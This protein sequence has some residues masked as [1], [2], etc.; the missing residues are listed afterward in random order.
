MTRLISVISI[1][2]LTIIGCESKNNGPDRIPDGVYIGTFQR[3]Q[4]FGGGEVAHVTITLSSNTWTGQ[5]DIIKYPAL[6]HG[7]Y[8]LDKQKIVFTNECAWTAE[9]DASLILGGAYDFKLNGTHLEIIRSFLG[10]STDTWS[11]IYTLTI[12]K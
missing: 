8:K 7:T 4:A 12:Q 1:L 2:F 9:F 10:P 3:Q 5:S 11:D 6:C